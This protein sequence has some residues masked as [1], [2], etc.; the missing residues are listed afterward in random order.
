MKKRS[1]LISLLSLVIMLSTMIPTSLTRILAKDGE[2]TV[3]YVVKEDAYL[4]NGSNADKNY[5]YENITKAHGAQYEN[6]GYRVINTKKDPANEII[7]VMKFDLPTKEEIETNKL[8]TYEFMFNIFKN[9]DPNTGDQDYIFHYTTDT[10]WSETTITWNNRPESIKYTNPNA[11]FTFHISKGD[12]YE[13]KTDEEKTIRVNITDIVENLVEAGEKEITVFVEAK[14]S[15]NTSLMMHAKETAGTERQAR[16]IASSQGIDLTKLEELIKAVEGVK[17]SEFT[18]DSYAVFKTALDTAKALVENKETDLPTIRKAYRTL[19]S[20]HESLVSLKDPND[21]DNVAYKKPTR[22]NLGKSIVQNVNDG[23][24]NTAWN[25]TFFPAYVDIDL[26]DTY[27]INKIKVNLPSGKKGY[28]TIYGSNDGKDFDRIYQLRESK[29]TPEAGSEIVFDAPENYRIV[30]IYDE[31]IEGDSKAYLSEVRIYGDKTN[32]NE[33][34]L[35]DGTI[36]EILGVKDFNDTAYAAPITTNETI[37]NVYGIIDRTIGAEY[38]S[39]FTFEIADMNSENDVFEISDKNGKIHI[40]GNEGLSLTTG[41]NYYFKN[42]LKVNIAEQT[43]QVK[44]PDKLASVGTTVVKETPYSVRYAFNYCTL[45]YTFA[46]FGEEDWQRENDWLALNGVNVVLDLA[47][48]EATWIKFLMNFGYSFDDAKDWLTGPGYYAWQFMDNMESF[49]GPV[50]DGYVVDR[51]ELARTSQRWK[52]SL[53][54]QTILQGYAGMVPTNFNEYQPDVTIINQ[55]NWNGFARPSMIATDSSTYDEYAEK[56]YEAQ[57][58]VYGET[59]D[60]YAVDP[61]HEG[62][63]R[64]QGLTDDTIASEVLESLLKYDSDAVWIVQGWQSNPT[65]KLL[66]GMGEHKNSH[67][68]IVDLIKYPI[69]SWTKYNKLTYDNTT[70]DSLE[71]NGTNWA[72]CLLGNF[73]GNPSM[74]GQMEV[75]VEDILNAQATSKHM[76]GIGIISE[77]TYDNPVLYDL[78]FDLAWADQDFNLDKWLNNYI[79]RRYG[80]VSENAKQAW[81]IMKDA[82]YDQGV[83]FT[84]EV[85]GTKN[86]A[87]QSYGKQTITYGA[88]NLET[89]LKLLAA[90]YEKFKDSEAY[91]YDLTEIMRQVVSNYAVLTYND[92]LTAKEEGNVDAFIEKKN[93]FLEIFDILNDVQATQQEQLGGEWIGKATDLAKDYDDF[94]KDTFEMNAKTL[95]T[96]WGSRSSHNSLKDYGWRNYEGIVQDVYKEVWVEYLNR[97][98]ANLRDGT[99]LNNKNVSQYFDFYWTWIMGDQDYTRE[100]KNSITDMKVV[101]DTVINQCSISEGLD[102]NIGNLALKR[103]ITTNVKNTVG[104]ISSAIDGSVDSKVTVKSTKDK[105]AEIIVNLIGEFDL[106]KIQVILDNENDADYQYEVYVS[107]D[108]ETWTKV[109][110]KK[111]ATVHDENGD[112]FE[113]SDCLGKYVKIVAISSSTNVNSPELSVREIR[114]YGERILPTLVQ[115]QSLVDTV[116]ELDF[117]GNSSN[118]QKQLQ[119]LVDKAKQGIKDGAAPDQV[120]ALYYELYD[121]T[122]SLS[123][124]TSVN[125]AKDKSVTAH[126]GTSGKPSNL[127]DGNKDSTWDSGRLSPPGLPYQDEIAPGSAVIDLEDVY[128]L[129]EIALT[130]KNLNIWHKYEIY[131]SITGNDDDWTKVG[132]KT[133]TTNPN[134][135][136]D[137]FYLEEAKGR[138]IKLVTTDIQL[139]SNGKRYGYL[140]AELEA[141]GALYTVDK[142]KLTELIEDVKQLNESD[143]TNE[144]WAVLKEAL[145][146]AITV[147]ETAYVSQTQIDDAYN[148]LFTATEGLAKKIDVSK[149]EALIKN[150]EKLD[151]SNCTEESVNALTTVLKEAKDLLSAN[152]IQK[153]VDA[154]IKKLQDAV[155]NLEIKVDVSKL[156]KLLQDVEKI[157][158]SKYT[159]ESVQ[160]LLDTLNEA[161][162][163]LSTNPTQK[164]VDKMVEKVLDAVSSL[165]IKDEEKLDTSKLEAIIEYAEKLDTSLYTAKTVE[166]LFDS[167]ND[168]K[169]VLDD[170]KNQKEIDDAYANIEKAIKALK[171]IESPSI[172]PDDKPSDSVKG[173]DPSTGDTVKIEWLLFLFV[174]S[175][176]SI[177]AYAKKRKKVN[178]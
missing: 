144:S 107:T 30:R 87:P 177:T 2:T 89:A 90:D 128:T 85:F 40:K 63:K 125:V 11:L 34:V 14:N 47:G 58:F 96:S 119:S 178:D 69:K 159:E 101:L 126:N 33:E 86:K 26:M 153:D 147:E 138:Y 145:D 168:G 43:M 9:A 123:I 105:N 52:N 3:E 161:K 150:V 172:T 139:E 41:L 35:R 31:F 6:L 25:G 114:A 116:E 8:D 49:G 171:D 154:M 5:N 64:P 133:T 62:G 102:P 175:G 39:W 84:N 76:Q 148:E 140:V 132:E 111:D 37:E 173:S 20:T 155:D 142:T 66:Q 88:E 78:I 44:M 56:F 108:K 129:D 36:E 75:M 149:L 29:D 16:I 136:E 4:R 15:M 122:T 112:V 23:D 91:R 70:L 118:Q 1:V 99:P 174:I 131:T 127:V 109:G 19:S 106:T 24:V 130:F 100:A 124:N 176:I 169:K 22:T 74:N 164:E 92:L 120:D 48:Q 98:E 77:A 57:R 54:M 137:T 12:A 79:E 50:P 21:E 28:Y 73:G 81:Q 143:Y 97:V 60:Y 32:A 103:A 163:L 65:N 152:P 13:S 93:E 18:E 135:K 151:T 10:T 156:E 7:S 158:T 162:D 167:I 42:Y 134:S 115:L 38:R 68:L 27:A 59:T 95:I 80:A 146:E 46:F 166:K 53:G 113:L 157:D 72:W 121:Y 83:R 165:K 94:G 17:A 117:T 71:F 160:I 61:F 51:L 45:S 104:R 67:V 55:G 170:A 141:F 110:E 82:N